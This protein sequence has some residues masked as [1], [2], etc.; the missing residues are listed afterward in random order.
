MSREL[1]SCFPFIMGVDGVSVN[2]SHK[3][4]AGGLTCKHYVVNT[5]EACPWI[6]SCNKRACLRLRNRSATL[7]YHDDPINLSRQNIQ[8]MPSRINLGFGAETFKKVRSLQAYRLP[9]LVCFEKV[10]E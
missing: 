1:L 2:F 10:M 9:P 8:Q 3:W 6:T 4:V 5:T 7:N